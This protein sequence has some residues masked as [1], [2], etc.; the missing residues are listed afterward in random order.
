MM[1]K[2]NER[3]AIMAQHYLICALFA[4]SEEGSYPRVTKQAREKAIVDCRMFCEMA[5]PE[6]LREVQRRK[7]DGYGAHPD[8][9]NVH[10]EFAAMGHDLWL[11]RNEHGAGFWDRE[12]LADDELGDKLSEIARKMGSADY[13]F[14]RGWFYLY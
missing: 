11:T 1:S 4:D 12:A 10:P 5:G 14:Y 3:I 6:L 7:V 8:C 2:D 9:G 13:E